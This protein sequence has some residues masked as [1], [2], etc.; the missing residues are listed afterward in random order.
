LTAGS[1]AGRKKLIDAAAGRDGS[2]KFFDYLLHCCCR[3]PIAYEPHVEIEVFRE[4][5]GTPNGRMNPGIRIPESSTS[6][7]SQKHKVRLSTLRVEDCGPHRGLV[8]SVEDE[9]SK[10]LSMLTFDGAIG[11]REGGAESLRN[12]RAVFASGFGRLDVPVQSNAEVSAKE[13]GLF[14]VEAGQVIRYGRKALTRA[15]RIPIPHLP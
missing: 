15:E 6:E 3:R 7:K 13:R 2:L 11:D 9:T 8:G 4:L 12:Q 10:F 1:S 5:Q 14:G